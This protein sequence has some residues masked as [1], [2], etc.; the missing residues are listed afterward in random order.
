[1]RLAR[2]RASALA[3]L[4]L[5]L[6]ARPAAAQQNRFADVQIETQQVA[7]RLYMLRGAGG[8]LGLFVGEDG[9][10]LI[11]DQFAPLTPKIKAA[12]GEITEQPVR[13][14]LNTHWH[15]DHT[16]GNENFGEAGALLVAQE[17]V[18]ERL[19]ESD[20]HEL[21][22]RE[23]PA[24]PD[25]AL[26]VVTFTDAMAFH[27]GEERLRVEHM[28]HAH[29]DGDAVVFFEQAGAVHTGDLYFAG[30]YPLIDIATGGSLDGMIDGTAR[31]L[32]QIDAD[33]P[34]IPGH[35]PLS[36]G[37]EL[38]DYHDMLATVRERVQSLVDEGLSLEEVL[39]EAPTADLDAEWDAQR[40]PK[41]FVTVVY[42][43][44]TGGLEQREE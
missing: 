37:A 29:T 10:F 15:P 39:A 41:A 36:D 8:N 1:M 12:I 11:D 6:C 44:L 17:N 26:P 16:G 19:S 30:G 28:P 25:A 38:Q 42:Q 2:L 34:V 20:F 40:P 24:A 5:L 18:R 14:V 4:V 13:F 35:G 43:D 7:D 21:F 32:E 33:T 9:A 31:I 27:V 23:I 3:A 22:E